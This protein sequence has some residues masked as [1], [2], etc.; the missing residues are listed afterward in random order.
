MEGIRIIEVAARDG[1]Q[2]EKVH[3]SVADRIKFIDLLAA[4]GLKWIEAGSFVHPKAVPQMIGSD[5][6]AAHY[7]VNP[8]SADL[9][10]LVPN[11]RGLETALANKVDHIAIFLAA[12]ESFSMANIRKSVAESFEA[13]REVV[14]EALAN[15]IRVRGYLS[16]IFKGVDGEVVDPN[17]VADLSV[18]LLNMGCYEVSLGDTTGVGKPEDTEA[19]IDAFVEK[20]I[21]LE[22]VAMHYHDTFGN[23]IANID[24]AYRKGIRSFDSSTAGIG[25]CPFAKSATGNVDTQKVL[26]W[27]KS[28]GIKN[29]GIDEASLQNAASFIEGALLKKS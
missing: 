2:N 21:P 5:E 8:S 18:K 9:S 20:N 14:D 22:K 1:L 24:A 12:T 17:Y 11:K 6:I 16:T 10:Y 25:G 19:L 7:A 23:A 26:T 15:G 4:A 27:A 13:I 28:V 29:L 3:L